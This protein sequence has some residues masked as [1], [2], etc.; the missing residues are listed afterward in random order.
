MSRCSQTM[1]TCPKCNKEHPFT[2]WESINTQLDPEMRPAVKDRSAFL[3]ECPTCGEKTYVDYGFLYHQMEDGIMIHYANSDENA[4]EI[5]KMITGDDSAGLFREMLDA[6]YLIRIVRSQ[7]DL[8]E[9]ISIFDEGLDDRIIEIIKLFVL[10]KF[11]DENK[12]YKSI[13]LYYSKNED[14]DCIEI[15]ADNQYSGHFVIPREFYDRLCKE[16]S[17]IIPDLRK[18]DPVIDRVWA[19][20]TLKLLEHKE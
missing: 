3:F 16:Y 15:Y 5:Y 12:D 1:I 4:E 9:K 13:A 10:S 6:D 19:L 2:I 8:R 20:E 14:D 7:N 11:Q 18:D 17:G